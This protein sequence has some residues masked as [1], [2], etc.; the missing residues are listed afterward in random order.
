MG[1]IGSGGLLGR[2]EAAVAGEEERITKGV[3]K[4]SKGTRQLREEF[5]LGFV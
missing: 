2:G 3:G 1:D 5:R 4:I